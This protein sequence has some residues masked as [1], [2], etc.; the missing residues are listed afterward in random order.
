MV[1]K[2]VCVSR[3]AVNFVNVALTRNNYVKVLYAILSATIINYDC[4]WEK[5]KGP[6]HVYIYVYN[7]FSV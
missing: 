7:D 6:F 4:T 2:V 1:V 5:G 3:I